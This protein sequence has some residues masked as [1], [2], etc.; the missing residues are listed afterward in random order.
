MAPGIK[1]PNMIY[2][3]DFGLARSIYT[4]SSKKQLRP[5]RAHVGL[6]FF[7]KIFDS[8]NIDFFPLT[9]S[10]PRN[11]SVLLSQCT[12]TTWTGTSR[13]SV[14]RVG[15]LQ[16]F[17][18]P[19]FINSLFNFSIPSSNWA[20]ADFHGQAFDHQP[21]SASRKASRTTCCSRLVN[22]CQ[23]KYNSIIQFP[24]PFTGF[25]CL[26]PH[27]APTIEPIQIRGWHQLRG[28]G[29]D[30]FQWD[31]NKKLQTHGALRMGEEPGSTEHNVYST[32]SRG[33]S[34]RPQTGQFID[35]VIK[36][37]IP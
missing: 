31:E 27:S 35:K 30:S 14:E 2:L 13:R 20:L 19:S 37:Y 25:S 5:P 32:E 17:S 6:L 34:T 24:K 23:Y 15:E 18:I 29:T 7:V 22:V 36:L 33:G 12:K 1:R 9:G 8:I 16:I 28:S 11:L 21:A 4:D 3:F 26:I 10:I